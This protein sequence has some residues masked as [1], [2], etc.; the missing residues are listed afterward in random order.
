MELP[1]TAIAVHAIKVT[2]ENHVIDSILFLMK[3]ILLQMQ[4]QLN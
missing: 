4:N 3:L 2:L 1:K